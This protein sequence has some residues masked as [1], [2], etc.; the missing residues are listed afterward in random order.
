MPSPS[1]RRSNGYLCRFKDL[2][3]KTLMLDEIM[4]IPESPERDYLIDFA[5]RS[6]RD[7]Q[8]LMRVGLSEL[9]QFVDDNQH[10]VRTRSDSRGTTWGCL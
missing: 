1:R 10:P 8:E 2:E 6:L 5:T 7:A 3:I 4:M 9:A